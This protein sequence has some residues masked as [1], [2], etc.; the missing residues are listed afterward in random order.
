MPV[1]PFV[2]AGLLLACLASFSWAMRHF[3]TRPAGDNAGMKLI[4]VCGSGFALLHLGAI[5]ATPHA[6][7]RQTLGGAAIYLCALVL[8]WW[9]IRANSR[10]PLSAAFSPDDPLHLVQHGPYRFIRHPFY[11]SYLLAWTAGIVATGRLWLLPSLAIMLAVYFRAA[12]MEEDKFARTALAD[13]YQRYRA[14]TGMFFPNPVKFG[15]AA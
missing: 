1:C 9:T 3:F 15:P 7:A 12:S 8:F 10:R 6:T 2:S 13:A 4:A 5:A 14:R 11:C